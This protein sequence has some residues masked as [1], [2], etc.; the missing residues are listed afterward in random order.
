MTRLCVALLLLLAACGRPSYV[1][2]AVDSNKTEVGLT[3]LRAQ[4]T[5]DGERANFNLI[6]GQPYE[7]LPGRP[8][9]FAVKFAS[10]KTGIARVEVTGW[11]ELMRI[12]QG[13]VDVP[14]IVGGSVEESLTLT[15]F[16]CGD[17]DQPC[18]GD[19]CDAGLVC[20]GTMVCRPCGDAGQPCC[21]GQACAS[22]LACVGGQTCAPCGGT[23]QPCCA[24]DAC[25]AMLT[26]AG[27]T[28]RCG[29]DGQ[30]CCPGDVCTAPAQ[31]AGGTC[32][33]G[34]A[35]EPC[36][37]GDAC[38]T[39]Y[40]CDASKQCVPCGAKGQPCCGT[41]CGANLT[42]AAGTCACGAA[43]QPCCDGSGCGAQLSC[44]PN[45]VPGNPPSCQSCLPGCQ[46]S[47][48]HKSNAAMTQ[49]EPCGT[50]NVQCC[51][52]DTC[53]PNLTCT[54]GSCRCGAKDQ[55]CCNGTTCN[56]NLTCKLG[57]CRCG[58][59]GE[60]CCSGTACNA[61]LECSGGSCVCGALGQVCCAGSAC[62]SGT[63]CSSGG[64]C[65]ACGGLNQPCCAGNGCTS[66][67]GCVGGECAVF[68]GAFMT[69]DPSCQSCLLGNP[70]GGACACPSGFNTDRAR[71]LNDCNTATGM[72]HGAHLNFCQSAAA[73]GGSDYGGF[74][75]LDDLNCR[76]ADRCAVKNRYTGACSCPAGMVAADLSVHVD[77]SSACSAWGYMG[78]HIF[79]CMPSTG[80]ITN[81]GGVYQVNELTCEGH[82]VCR[83]GNPRGEGGCACAPGTSPKGIGRVWA[84]CNNFTRAWST[85]YACTP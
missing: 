85:V 31:C 34:G 18:C 73:V 53:D 11:R 49:C 23:D 36:C 6:E 29:G 5:L 30:P 4:V 72:T 50:Q 1:V 42:C 37:A 43:G 59:A 39:G 16:I 63:A 21:G 3:A 55:P 77:V 71:A 68:G 52:G 70:F 47:V 33:C 14:I 69:Q 81:F 22:G 13:T 8:L 66:G 17:L 84:D 67:M 62:N 26:C 38:D 25:G 76:A 32:V 83:A 15:P 35:G 24:G 57:T 9:T 12:V 65:V 46:S 80:P 56:A 64:T 61:N 40:T 41:S 82:G 74:Y 2:L 54:G 60:K 28:C 45:P 27:G 78:S 44:Q 48:N 51:G 79:V 10:G 20:D 7:L 19:T 75:Q 58:G